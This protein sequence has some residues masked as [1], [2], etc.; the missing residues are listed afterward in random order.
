MKQTHEA[1]QW[2]T[3]LPYL[4]NKKY[5]EK[6]FIYSLTKIQSVT[7][8]ISVE[9]HKKKLSALVKS[10][11]MGI[12]FTI[13]FKVILDSRK[14]FSFLSMLVDKHHNS[15]TYCDLRGSRYS[16]IYQYCDIKTFEHHNIFSFSNEID[17]PKETSEEM[18]K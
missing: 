3:Y 9:E 15:I 1:G 7:L 18:N 4:S 16:S 10:H 5:I 13:F 6:P 14:N 2:F 17:F 12:G 8:L 11:P